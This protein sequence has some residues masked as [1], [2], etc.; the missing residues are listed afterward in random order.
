ML[1]VNIKGARGTSGPKCRSSLTEAAARPRRAAAMGSVKTI[2][3]V[4]IW[5]PKRTAYHIQ[6]RVNTNLLVHHHPL[7]LENI[8][9]IHNMDK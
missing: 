7:Q 6:N 2:D 3:N 1:G 5:D 8:V 9:N 4:I